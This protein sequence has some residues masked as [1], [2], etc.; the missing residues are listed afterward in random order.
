MTMMALLLL[1]T[2]AIAQPQRGSQGARG[3]KG[4]PLTE[5]DLSQEQKAQIKEIQKST[6]AEMQALRSANSEQ[7]LDRDAMKKI[8]EDAREKM[9]AVL[10][11]EQKTKLTALKEERKAAW[12]SVDKE[13]LKS[14]LKAHHEEV[15]AVVQA[16]RAQLDPFISPEDQVSIERLRAVFD[17]QPKHSRKGRRG[18]A[19]QEAEN[20]TNQR[21]A[22]KAW[23]DD[24][25]KEI[26][27][28]KALAEKYSEDIRRIHEKLKPQA[29]EWREEKREILN[30][31]FPEELQGTK[32][33]RQDKLRAAKPRTEKPSRGQQNNRKDK[34]GV[35]FLLMKS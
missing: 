10:T 1:T 7:R 34:K 30:S 20:K 6:R 14:D 28:A 13:A 26:E 5:L 17:T 29:K 18:G 32:Q 15:K 16:A 33:G 22:M 4:L 8:M 21:E 9:E 25:A 19:G 35:A 31:Y 24:H 2:V 23:A 3:G 11:P 27:E 12:E